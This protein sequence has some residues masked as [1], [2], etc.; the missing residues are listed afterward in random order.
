VIDQRR[1][2][3]KAQ[4]QREH[5]DR[6]VIAAVASARK[7]RDVTQAELAERLGWSREIV[8]NIEQGRRGVT[9]SDL[10]LIGRALNIE[11][12]T[13]FRRILHW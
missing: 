11:P 10:I 4:R 13:L 6:A 7:D 1:A 9:V 5:W 2:T 3:H 8:S 12:E